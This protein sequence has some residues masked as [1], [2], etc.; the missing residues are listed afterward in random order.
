MS[1]QVSRTPVQRSIGKF[2]DLP[3]I[4]ATQREGDQLPALPLRTH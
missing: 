1:R 2:F 4:D 3:I